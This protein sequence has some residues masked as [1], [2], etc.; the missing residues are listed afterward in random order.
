MRCTT[1]GVLVGGISVGRLDSAKKIVGV[2][3]GGGARVGGTGVGTLFAK[4]GRLQE[5]TNRLR[6]DKIRM[7]CSRRFMDNS[8]YLV[9]RFYYAFLKKK[10]QWFFRGG[11]C[12]ALSPSNFQTPD[13][14]KTCW[15]ECTNLIISCNLPKDSIEYRHLSVPR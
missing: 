11:S 5:M 8:F 9:R 1:D 10:L 13:L 6:I 3:T 7:I 14:K 2:G 15:G 4:K 12:S